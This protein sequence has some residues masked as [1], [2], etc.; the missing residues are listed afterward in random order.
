MK[1]LSLFLA[2]LLVSSIFATAFVLA[3]AEDTDAPET[4]NVKSDLGIEDQSALAGLVKEANSTLQGYRHFGGSQVTYAQGWATFDDSGYL[5]NVLWVSQTFA[6][7]SVEEI[8]D[9]REQYKDCMENEERRNRTCIYNATQA[10][11]DVANETIQKR[12][13]GKLQLGVGR[14]H[15]NFKLVKNEFT[16]DSVNF[17]V[18]TIDSRNATRDKVGTLDLEATHYSDMTLWQGQLVIE[19]G[20]RAGT[21][22]VS[23]ASKSA[24]VIGLGLNNIESISNKK[25]FWQRLMFWRR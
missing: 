25:G 2:L 20:D 3:D 7:A 16:N 12:S 6:K 22:E 8:R 24:I 18:Y 23:L 14:N 5:V 15:Q 21:Y 13:F 9:I 19:S 4:N 1:K 11:K 10:L 17:D